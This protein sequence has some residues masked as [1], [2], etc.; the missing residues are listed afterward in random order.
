MPTPDPKPTAADLRAMA[1][2][3]TSTWPA[4]ALR[5]GADAMDE[6]A[7]AGKRI[8]ELEAGLWW[9][10]WSLR[11]WQDSGHDEHAEECQLAQADAQSLL[12]AKP[13]TGG[14]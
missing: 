9:L 8:A 7:A 6:L 14:V 10:F 12:L 13:A 4:A 11:R 3:A 2:C 5:A 1:G